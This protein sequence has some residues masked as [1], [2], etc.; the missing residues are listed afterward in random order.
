MT[1]WHAL[2]RMGKPV[3]PGSTVLVLGTG[4]VS[5]FALQFA[6]SAGAQVIAT[7]SSDEKLARVRALGASAGINYVTTPDWDQEV[8]RL[9][10]GRG[11]DCII[12]VG[13]VG[14]LQRSIN[15]LGR[16]RKDHVDW[17]ADRP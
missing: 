7:S 11:A 3:M 10:A 8:M 1:A 17:P 4:G 15:A 14:T 5:I 13:G 16:G 6:R 12:E 2:F 9:T